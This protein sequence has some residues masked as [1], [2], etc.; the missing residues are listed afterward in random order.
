VTVIVGAGAC[1]S[2]SNSPNAC[3]APAAGDYIVD[4]Q[5][6]SG[7]CANECPAAFS[8]LVHVDSASQGSVVGAPVV[9]DCL[10]GDFGPFN[11][12]NSN[13]TSTMSCCTDTTSGCT[14]GTQV[15]IVACTQ[16]DPKLSG[17]IDEERFRF[18]LDAQGNL[19]AGNGSATGASGSVATYSAGEVANQTL[20]CGWSLSGKRSQ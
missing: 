12:A 4:M 9:D 11:P 16:P 13:C 17:E 10:T 3:A 19:V 1:S 6:G 5:G 14:P 20:F 7:D 2:S 8:V 18:E 15:I